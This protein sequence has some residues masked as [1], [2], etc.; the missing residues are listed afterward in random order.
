[1]T[2]T[3][4]QLTIVLHSLPAILLQIS[5]AYLPQPSLALMKVVSV[6]PSCDL[7]LTSTCLRDGHDDDAELPCCSSYIGRCSWWDP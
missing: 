4:V 3:M 5:N 2:Y 7:L 6:N 1:M